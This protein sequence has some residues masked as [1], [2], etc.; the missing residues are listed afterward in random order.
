M[1]LLID[2]DYVKNE[3]S[4]IK[5]AS[6]IGWVA[7]HDTDADIIDFLYDKCFTNR[8]DRS[9]I[10]NYARNGFET[11]N[12]NQILI[13]IDDVRKIL[14]SGSKT[15]YKDLRMYVF[16]LTET[17][18]RTGVAPIS[19]NTFIKKGHMTGSSIKKR[20]NA[21]IHKHHV[22]SSSTYKSRKNGFFYKVYAI[23][24]NA[25]YLRTYNPQYHIDHNKDYDRMSDHEREYYFNSIAISASNILNHP[26]KE[27]NSIIIDE[28][29]KISFAKLNKIFK[30]LLR[31]SDEERKYARENK[32]TPRSRLET[33]HNGCASKLEKFP[34]TSYLYKRYMAWLI[35]KEELFAVA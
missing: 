4:G 19:Y 11:A 7:T 10:R 27:K 16:S 32:T 6:Y 29:G 22:M 5:I 21:L 25:K 14:Q 8:M 33:N 2:K 15:R 30:Y 9:R 35:E 24:K 18:E 13:N 12:E 26:E 3:R 31:P 1:N 20:M 28:K 34:I 17:D 23:R